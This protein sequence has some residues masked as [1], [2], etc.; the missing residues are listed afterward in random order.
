V[1]AHNNNDASSSS[2][3]TSSDHDAP[4]WS[5]PRTIDA[6]DSLKILYT[7]T[8]LAKSEGAAMT[9]L[10]CDSCDAWSHIRCV[11]MAGYGIH[12]CKACADGDDDEEIEKY[13]NYYGM[14]PF[15]HGGKKYDAHKSDLD[16]RKLAS[17]LKNGKENAYD[18]K[19]FG[20]YYGN[21]GEWR[22]ELAKKVLGRKKKKKNVKVSD[23]NE[24]E[25]CD[26]DAKM[27]DADDDAKVIDADDEAKMIAADDDA[28]MIDA[29]ED[30][31]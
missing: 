11:E 16:G 25:R 20:D 28:K 6:Y 21:G 27:I 3:Y 18:R 10:H 17:A 7:R 2:D 31:D 9:W 1:C 19:L 14:D 15:T 4:V 12:Y 23:S 26:E 8:A 13:L 22:A 29:D 24:E 30:C 5:S